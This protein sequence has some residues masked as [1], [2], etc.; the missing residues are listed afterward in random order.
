MKYCSY[1]LTPIKQL[2]RF[3]SELVQREG[4][5]INCN[6][7]YYDYHPWKEF[8]D[9]SVEEFLTKLQKNGLSDQIKAVLDLDRKR[10]SISHNDF[11]NHSFNEVGKCSKL[12]FTNR[13]DLITFLS[14]LK[15]GSYLRVDFNNSL[16]S[17]ETYSLWLSL[18]VQEQ[19]L[20]EFFEDPC[21]ESEGW[22]ALR[23]AGIKI[24][25]DR[26]LGISQNFDFRILKPNVDMII[27]EDKKVIYS[28]YMGHDLGRY[29][30][31]LALM[32]NGDLSLYHGIDTPGIY[33]EQ[34]TLFHHLGEN[35]LKIDKDT[36][37]KLYEELEE[38]EWI[39]L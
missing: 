5:L 10:A 22:S 21:P 12:K 14:K 9:D 30:S 33:Q 29:H 36:V 28:S 38:L 16:S 39:D 13:S 7:L 23:E 35:R 2:N 19:A 15:Q 32:E 3:S 31:Y 4:V 20:I 6:G 27:H 34:R 8:G 1:K 25:C 37:R 24:A 11:L 26:N 18:S 17:H